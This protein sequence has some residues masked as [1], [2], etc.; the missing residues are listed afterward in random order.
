LI[1][2]FDLKRPLAPQANAVAQLELPAETPELDIVYDVW[3]YKYQ[4]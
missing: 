4:N 2:L 1:T 3:K